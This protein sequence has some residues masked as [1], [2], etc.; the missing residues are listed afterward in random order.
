[1]GAVR[2]GQVGPEV[3]RA[4]YVRRWPS[5]SLARPSATSATARSTS[6]SVERA[7]RRREHEPERETASVVGEWPAAVDVEQL[8]RREQRAGMPADGGLDLA[9]RSVVGDDHGQ[10]ALHD[11]VA[12]RRPSE[13][14]RRLAAG[15]AG[16][17]E[18]RHD[19][20]LRSQP[21]LVDERRMELAD[22]PGERVAGHDPGGPAGMEQSDRR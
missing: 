21:E 5:T 10:V 1:M 15:Q 17:G 9:R 12:R 3:G 2:C 16:H 6:S 22:A 7:V 4:G 20:P 11:R 8:D 13:R 19:D 18:L 14:H